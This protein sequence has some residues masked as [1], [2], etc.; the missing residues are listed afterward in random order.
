MAYIYI[1]IYISTN[2]TIINNL[3]FYET[4][5]QHRTEKSIQSVILTYGSEEVVASLSKAYPIRI[6]VRTSERGL[7]SAVCKGFNEACG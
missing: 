4:K 2:L 3:I 1:Y 7:S 6:I 5:E